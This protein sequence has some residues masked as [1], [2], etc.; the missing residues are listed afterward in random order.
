RWHIGLAALARDM[1]PDE[2]YD[3]LARLALRRRDAERIVGAVTVAPRIVE[4]LRSENLD[5]AQVVAL[6]D[7]FAPDAP[8]LALAMEER[9][10]LRAYFGRL[11]DVR[12]EIGGADLIELGLPESPQIGEILGEIRRRKLNGELTS[13][14]EELAAARELVAASVPA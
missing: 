6:A 7:P 4:R 8:L 2:A 10:E 11:R 5:A 12:L 9:P 3:W 13:R 1:P 14:D